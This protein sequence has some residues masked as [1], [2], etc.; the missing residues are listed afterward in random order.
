MLN[1]SSLLSLLCAVCGDDHMM[2]L[3]PCVERG[4]AIHKTETQNRL[5]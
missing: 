3:L 2:V 1:W 4:T 5:L